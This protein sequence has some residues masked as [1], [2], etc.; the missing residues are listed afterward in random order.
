MNPHSVKVLLG[1]H[2]NDRDLSEITQL[3]LRAWPGVLARSDVPPEDAAELAY[4]AAAS[5]L[6]AMRQAEGAYR[7][8]SWRP[9]DRTW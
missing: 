7:Y 1:K 3:A 8:Q 5:M 6:E 4:R 9:K 2:C